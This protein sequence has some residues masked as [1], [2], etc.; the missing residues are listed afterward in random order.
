MIEHREQANRILEHFIELLDIP[1]HYYDLAKR[2]YE[3]LADWFHREASSVARFDP[4]VYP[5]GSFRLGTVIRPLSDAE[6]YDLDLVSVL[7]LLSKADLSQAD[8]KRLVGEEVNR[9]DALCLLKRPSSRVPSPT[10]PRPT[11]VVSSTRNSSKA[12]TAHCPPTRC[13]WNPTSSHSPP[14]APLPPPELLIR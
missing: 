13:R 11:C 10:N 14:E 1:P 8:L 2:R 7:T 4:A 3:S 9:T 6:E 12:G 5:Q